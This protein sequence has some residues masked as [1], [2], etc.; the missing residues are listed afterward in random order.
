M[1]NLPFARKFNPFRPYGKMRTAHFIGNARK[2][3]VLLRLYIKLFRIV[4]S[5]AKTHRIEGVSDEE[6]RLFI[7]GSILGVCDQEKSRLD[8][9][10]H[11]LYAA[12]SCAE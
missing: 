1:A 3:A 6:R 7:A 2:S 10:S 5:R 9:V 4:K 11:A 12:P 8:K